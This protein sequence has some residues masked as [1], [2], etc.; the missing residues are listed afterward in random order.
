MSKNYQ[1]Y[2]ALAKDTSG[3]RQ[4]IQAVEDDLNSQTHYIIPLN[5][6]KSAQSNIQDGDI[7]T[8]A[9]STAGLD[10]G[11]LGLAFNGKLLHAS[12][13]KKEVIL[14]SSIYDYARKDKKNIGVSVLR[15]G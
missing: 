5:K 8:I 15:L 13:R 7:I 10:Y 4:Q 9:I 3:L 12:S 14:D 2:P 1:K 11:H 6:L